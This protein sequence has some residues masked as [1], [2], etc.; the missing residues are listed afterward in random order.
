MP[1]LRHSPDPEAR[2]RVS[3]GG[4]C[5]SH[6]LLMDTSLY[7]SWFP[8]GVGPADAGAR[9]FCLPFAGGGASNFAAWRNKF[10]SVG[11]IPVQYPGHETRIDEVPLAKMDDMLD[12]LRDAFALLLDRPYVLFG[13]SMGARIAFGLIRK[14]A[15]QDL[16]PPAA[17]VVAAHVPPDRTSGASR[18]IGL[19]DPAFK[20]VLRAYGGMPGDL[21]DD[22]EFCAM[23]LPV[24]RA[25]FTLAVQ[26]VPLAP[27]DCPIIAYAGR[28]DATASPAAMDGWQRFTTDR[29]HLREFDG[30][31]FFLRT[32]S[33]LERALREDLSAVLPA[34][35]AY[36]ASA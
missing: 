34:S 24:M 35:Q 31:H 30:E 28:Q 23:A 29:F 14:L 3:S 2:S 4:I 33:G 32:A 22:D 1:V 11:I 6:D 7:R 19:S 27:V 5:V 15:D 20:E 10:D 18:A 17:L 16:P 8:F 36:F 12:G 21:L 9:L 25:D 13:Y 26:Q